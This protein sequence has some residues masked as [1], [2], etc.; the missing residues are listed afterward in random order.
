M[1]AL[2][3]SKTKAPRF[4]FDDAERLA[5][6]VDRPMITPLCGNLYRHFLVLPSRTTRRP[7][8]Y[9]QAFSA[10]AGRWLILLIEGSKRNT[11]QITV[12]ALEASGLSYTV[13]SQL[14][15]QSSRRR[16]AADVLS[17]KHRVASQS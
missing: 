14:R 13:A 16:S 4:D 6:V 3:R 8:A 2:L 9:G 7:L 1:S 15:E 12:A 10:V 17:A 5:A 11:V